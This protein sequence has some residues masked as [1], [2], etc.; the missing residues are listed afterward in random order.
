MPLDRTW[1]SMTLNETL[2]GIIGACNYKNDLSVDQ[3]WV[4]D[5]KTIL[6]KT[7]ANPRKPLGQFA[8]GLQ[9]RS[10]LIRK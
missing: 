9:P 2:S 8:D 7:A 5:Y 3:P 10:A 1:L 4:E 6:A